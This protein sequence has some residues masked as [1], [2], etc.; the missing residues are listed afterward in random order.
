MS[1]RDFSL[2]ARHLGQPH[3]V[4]LRRSHVGGRELADQER[5]E[6]IAVGKL[7]DARR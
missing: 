2:A 7:P 3:L 6:G 1:A 5:V 4:D